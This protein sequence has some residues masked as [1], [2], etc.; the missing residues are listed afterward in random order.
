MAGFTKDPAAGDAALIV[1]NGGRTIFRGFLDAQNSADLDN[2]AKPDRMEL[3]VNLVSHMLG[4]AGFQ[5]PDVPALPHKIPPLESLSIEVTF[6]PKA[7]STNRATLTILSNDE[8]EPAVEVG[9]ERG[10]ACARRL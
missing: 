3:W 8:D 10:G 2:D 7:V 5:L 6:S 4:I 1:A 9:L